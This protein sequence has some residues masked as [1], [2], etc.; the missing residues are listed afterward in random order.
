[1]AVPLAA[2]LA[3][4]CVPQPL[5]VTVQPRGSGPPGTE[6]TVSA[7]GFDPGR[8]EIRWNAVD[9]KLLAAP[10]GPDFSA[11]VVIPQAS[12]GLYHLVVLARSAGGEIGNTAAVSFYVTA[13]AGAAP[14]A[15]RR[16]VAEEAPSSSSSADAGT[17]VAAGTGAAVALAVAGGAALA[18]RRRRV[19]SAGGGPEAG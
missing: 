5:L 19:A 6:V 3:W 18:A 8:A 7:L 2:P 9:G 15:P 13:E 1:M 10:D 16:W 14:P 12:E 17:A 4:A 11:P